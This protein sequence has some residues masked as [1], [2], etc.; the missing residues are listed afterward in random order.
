LLDQPIDL[1]KLDV[2][3]VETTV[4]QEAADKL[5]QVEQ[6]YLEFHGSS[7]NPDNQLKM[8]V[9]VLQQAG[10]KLTFKE[11]GQ[12]VGLADLSHDDPQWVIVHAKRT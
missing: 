5:S 7:A 2:E 9:D 10:F 8:I 1:L 6:L 12:L 3:G 11:K 4:L